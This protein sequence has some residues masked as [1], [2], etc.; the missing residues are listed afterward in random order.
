[1]KIVPTPA[2]RRALRAEAH[3]LDPVVMIGNDGVTPAVLHEI[4]LNLLAHGLIKVRVFSDERAVREGFLQR[5]VDE[6]DAAAI[7]HI[8]KLLVV[9]PSAQAAGHRRSTHAPPIH[10]RQPSRELYGRQPSQEDHRGGHRIKS[11]TACRG[12]YGIEPQAAC[13]SHHHS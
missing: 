11:Q 10:G 6:L 13:R 7:Q 2:R 4:D 9:S 12:W 8:G 3:H 5:I 1:M